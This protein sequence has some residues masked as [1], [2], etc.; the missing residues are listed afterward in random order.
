MKTKRFLAAL[1][2]VLVLVGSFPCMAFAA[3]NSDEN[4]EITSHTIVLSVP[5]ADPDDSGIAPCIWGQTGPTIGA[6][7]SVPTAE[8]YIPE[9]Y[10]AF[11]SYASG[12]SNGLYSVT[13]RYG[14]SF[15]ESHYNNINSDAEKSD[16]ITINSYGNYHFVITNSANCPITV[17]ITYYSWK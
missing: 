11:E 7:G 5:A 10:F 2:T 12:N 13:L 17:T 6:N 8:F 1:L 15:I 9:R 3:D 4:P 14:T 16:W